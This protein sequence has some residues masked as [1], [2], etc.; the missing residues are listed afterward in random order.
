[1]TN[2]SFIFLVEAGYEKIPE[3]VTL[4]NKMSVLDPTSINS[5]HGHV[6]RNINLITTLAQFHY[7]YIE[8]RKYHF[9]EETIT[10]ELEIFGCE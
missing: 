5:V 6:A 3:N 9:L 4:G 8:I 2:R 10:L 7:P 1:M